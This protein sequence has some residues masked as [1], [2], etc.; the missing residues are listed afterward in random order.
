MIYII[1]TSENTPMPN[2][3]HQSCSAKGP[4]LPTKAKLPT[5]SPSAR[6]AP[7]PRLQPTAWVAPG[8]HGPCK[9]CPHIGGFHLPVL[10]EPPTGAFLLETFKISPADGIA[11]RGSQ[12]TAIFTYFPYQQL[13]FFLFPFLIIK[14]FC[15]KKLSHSQGKKKY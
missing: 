7:A 13:L 9:P 3:R 15:F 10:P 6:L 12:Q 8:A 11:E 14:S 2:R 4:T 5:Q 1:Y